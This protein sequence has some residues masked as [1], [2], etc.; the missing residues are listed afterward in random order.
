MYS[1]HVQYVSGIRGIAMYLCLFQIAITVM[2][3]CI[4][5]R[6]RFGSIRS[7]PGR[8]MYL[9]DPKPINLL[10]V[11]IFYVRCIPTTYQEFAQ[12]CYP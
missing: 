8:S 3:P 4:V 7:V 6:F 5:I 1:K 10:D 2:I 11:W 9:V 12:F